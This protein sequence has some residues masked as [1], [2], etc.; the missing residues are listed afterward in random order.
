MSFRQERG[1]SGILPVEVLDGVS[2]ASR[3]EAR[4]EGR[5]AHSVLRYAVPEKTI[6]SAG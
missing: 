3:F 2:T 5:S 4:E 6:A 1:N